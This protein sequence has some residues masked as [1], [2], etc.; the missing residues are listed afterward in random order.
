LVQQWWSY[1]GDS[2]RPDTSQM[3]LQY[4]LQYI[5]PDNWQVGMAPNITVNWK[6]DGDNKL[7]LPIGLGVGKLFPFGKLPVRFTLEVDY[8]VVRP[9]DF[10]QRWLVRLQMIPV[11]PALFKDPLIKW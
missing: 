9:D 5:L 3:N 6:A 1:A 7:N 8:S 4:F 11:L 10:S 2:K